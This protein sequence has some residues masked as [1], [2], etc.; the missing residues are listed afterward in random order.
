MPVEP[1]VTEMT[2]GILASSIVN[3]I[4]MI[5]AEMPVN[6]GTSP[7]A[8]AMSTAMPIVR[9]AVMAADHQV[10]RTVASLIHSLRSCRANGSR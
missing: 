3:W 7:T 2:P 9:A 6:P 1:A 4:G 5:T 10:E 8:S